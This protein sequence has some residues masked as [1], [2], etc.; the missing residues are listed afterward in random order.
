MHFQIEFEPNGD[1]YSFR[2]AHKVRPGD[3]AWVQGQYGTGVS[4]VK[5]LV[6]GIKQLQAEK[7]GKHGNIY[8]RDPDTHELTYELEPAN[9]IESVK[10]TAE[11]AEYGVLITHPDFAHKLVYSFAAGRLFHCEP[12]ED[13]QQTLLRMWAGEWFDKADQ[14]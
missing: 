12:G 6:V 7:V 11:N 9:H 13:P 8:V 2:A 10:F 5:A 3:W 14:L 4:P 1:V